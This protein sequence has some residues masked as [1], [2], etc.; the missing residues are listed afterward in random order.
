M[1]MRDSPP[2]AAARRRLC[3]SMSSRILWWPVP[4]ISAGLRSAA[5]TTLPSITTRRRSSPGARCSINT[6]GCSS[7][8]RASAASSSSPSADA[9]GDALA[10]F[11]AGGLDDDVADLLEERVVVFVEGGQTS[12][13]HLDSG[14]RHQTPGQPL[15]VTPRHRHRGGV[16]RQRLSGDDA[17]ARRGTAASRRLPASR[18]S[19]QIPRRIASSAMIRA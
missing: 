2:V 15:V 7:R 16:L 5:A 4:M 12:L 18:T 9:D 10:L 14:L 19:T 1:G 6:A 13:G 8:A 17:A 3:A 11:P